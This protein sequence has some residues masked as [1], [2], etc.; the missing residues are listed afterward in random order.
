MNAPTLAITVGEPAGIG[1][2]LVALLAAR[3]RAHPYPFRLVVI[4]DRDVLRARATRIGSAPEYVD[5]DPDRV[6][7]P[8]PILHASR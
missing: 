7:A 3:H 5:Y 1:P 2:E 8:P 4:G 6:A